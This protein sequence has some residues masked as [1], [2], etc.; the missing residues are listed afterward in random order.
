MHHRDDKYNL[1]KVAKEQG[2][3]YYWRSKRPIYQGLGAGTGTSE[4]ETSC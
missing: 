2:P 3:T 4:S 1:R